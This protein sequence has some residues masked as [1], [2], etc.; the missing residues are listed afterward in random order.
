MKSGFFRG[1]GLGNDYLVMDRKDL[2]FKLTPKTIK[3]ICDRN[4][5]LGSDGILSLVPSK[6]ADFGLR[7]STRTAVRQKNQGTASESSRLILTRPAK[8][9]RNASK[10]RQRAG[11][12]VLNFR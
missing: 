5:G 12:S 6:K 10:S 3:A 8:Q 1:R 2:T 7:I 9:R 4:W 11:W